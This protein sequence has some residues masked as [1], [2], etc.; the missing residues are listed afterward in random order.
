MKNSGTISITR[1]ARLYRAEK[2]RM[3]FRQHIANTEQRASALVS[4]SIFRQI[5][6]ARAI[7]R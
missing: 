4:S 7:L 3:A 2:K 1:R 5:S 6:L